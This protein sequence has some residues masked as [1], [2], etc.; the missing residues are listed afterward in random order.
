MFMVENMAS[1]LMKLKTEKIGY[2]SILVILYVLSM[3]FGLYIM[4]NRFEFFF[5]L[6]TL[7][8]NLASWLMYLNTE[9]MGFTF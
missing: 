7:L 2:T 9:R 5:F 4:V 6:Y 8:K 3:A 1:W